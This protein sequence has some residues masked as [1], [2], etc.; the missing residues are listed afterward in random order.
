MKCLSVHQPWADL[1]VDGRRGLE[2]R[3]WPCSHRGPL[4]IHAGLQV[5]QKECLRLKVSPSVRGAIIGL[6]NLVDI[7]PLTEREWKQLRW[8]H[9]ESGDRC[10]GEKTFGWFL[11]DAQRFLTPIP[12]RGVLGIFDVDD[13]IL[14][15]FKPSR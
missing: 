2:I 1:E 13:G 8:V 4:L 14:P 5:E 6:V 3:K 15:L 11:K 12:Y 7:K 10:Y 9:L